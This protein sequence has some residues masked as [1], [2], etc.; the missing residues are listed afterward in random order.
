VSYR[1]KVQVGNEY[2][3]CTSPFRLHDMI[4]DLTSDSPSLDELRA[5]VK[6][7]TPPP[8]RRAKLEDIV[9]TLE[10]YNPPPDKIK[11]EHTA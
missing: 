1:F 7:E 10:P 8:V 6:G 9:I 3:Y 11:W 5:K 4:E 2:A